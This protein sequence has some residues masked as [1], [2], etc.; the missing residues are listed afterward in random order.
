MLVFCVKQALFYENSIIWLIKE[1]FHDQKRKKEGSYIRF[2]RQNAG[3]NA[4]NR[5][6]VNCDK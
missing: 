6:F 5:R 2:S 4:I 1:S 3:K